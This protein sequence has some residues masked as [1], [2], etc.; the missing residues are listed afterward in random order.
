MVICVCV[1]IVLQMLSRKMMA[2]AK[3]E[4]VRLTRLKKFFIV[5]MAIFIFKQLQASCAA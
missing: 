3:I 4:A 1:C 2:V 5:N